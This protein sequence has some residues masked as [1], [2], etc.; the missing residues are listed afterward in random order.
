VII[1]PGEIPHFKTSK[2]FPLLKLYMPLWKRKEVKECIKDRQVGDDQMTLNF[3]QNKS[4]PL[5]ISVEFDYIFDKYGIARNSSM[6]DLFGY[7]MRFLLKKNYPEEELRD[8][9]RNMSNPNFEN[10]FNNAACL[11]KSNELVFVENH[12]LFQMDISKDYLSFHNIIS[13]QKLKKTIEKNFRNMNTVTLYTMYEEFKLKQERFGSL[14]G[15]I[16]KIL[17]ERTMFE[18][19]CNIIRKFYPDNLYIKKNLIDMN[20]VFNNIK[21]IKQVEFTYI[22]TELEENVLYCQNKSNWETVDYL[23]HLKV[24]KFYYLFG[25]QVTISKTHSINATGINKIKIII[26]NFKKRK[27]KK[28]YYVHLFIVQNLSLFKAKKK[29]VELEKENHEIQTIQIRF[30]KRDN[31]NNNNNGDNN[32]GDNSNSNNG[33]NNNNNNGD[34]N[35]NNNNGDGCNDS[36]YYDNNIDGIKKKKRKRESVD[37]FK[38]KEKENLRN[39]FPYY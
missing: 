33:D 25:I 31:N 39:I 35:N 37:D 20:D 38:G 34:N 11:N 6:F 14:V 3:L 1:S 4:L 15:G 13:G 18:E 9:F 7:L 28:L 24:R 36:Y 23:L 5:S 22:Q 8:V 27:K 32:N 12:H 21:T 30:S 17:L 29:I 16:F 2:R 19:N 26:N 10:I